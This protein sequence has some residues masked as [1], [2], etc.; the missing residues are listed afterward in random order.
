[1]RSPPD[2]A[3][4]STAGA[5]ELPVPVLGRARVAN[6]A[7]AYPRFWRSVDL[8]SVDADGRTGVMIYRD[9]E[10]ATL[11][12]IAASREGIYKVMWVWNPS[13]IA[14]CLDSRSRFAAALGS[15]PGPGVL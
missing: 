8:R 2:T 4:T 11:L 5:N 13:K 14:V 7:S 6:L 1:M 10:P 3:L 15:E 9:G 12:G